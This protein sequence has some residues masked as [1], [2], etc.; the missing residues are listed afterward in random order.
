MLPLKQTLEKYNQS[1]SGGVF[2]SRKVKYIIE[3]K[4]LLTRSLSTSHSVSGDGRDEQQGR[5]R[6]GQETS[7]EIS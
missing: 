3:A 2:M 7:C 4:I 6:G 5:P 1:S